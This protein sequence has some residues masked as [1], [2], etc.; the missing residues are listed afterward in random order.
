[1]K[2]FK[3]EIYRNES[4]IDS[5]ALFNSIGLH[6]NGYTQW[7]RRFKELGQENV[8]YYKKQSMILDPQKIKMRYRYHV[9]LLFACELCVAARTFQG[10]ELKYELRRVFW[11]SI[12]KR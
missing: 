9:T 5:L 1:M 12:K 11:D 2:V 8:D 7:I 10:K 3:V 4:C 6:K